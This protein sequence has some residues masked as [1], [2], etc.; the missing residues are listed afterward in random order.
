MKMGGY[1]REIFGLFVYSSELVLSKSRAI[2]NQEGNL[3][4]TVPMEQ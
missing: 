4:F 2:E 3:N 1:N